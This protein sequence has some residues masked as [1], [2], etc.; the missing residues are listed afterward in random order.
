MSKLIILALAAAAA[1]TATA[2]ST[3]VDVSDFTGNGKLVLNA[4]AAPAGQTMDVK[5]QHSDT[6]GSGYAD[7]GVAFTQVT[8]AGANFEVK[9]VSLDQF[10]KYV[11]VV[12]TIAGGTTAHPY[13][14]TLVGNKAL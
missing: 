12:A 3:G 5:V 13:T 9:D 4:A 1:P 8:S 14:V 11:R 7:S 6:L 10:K 2:T